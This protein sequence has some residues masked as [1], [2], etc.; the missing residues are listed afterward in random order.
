VIKFIVV[1][2]NGNPLSDV[3]VSF[4]MVGPNGG[5][6]IDPSGDATPGE[7]DVS[8]NDEGIAQ[9][10]LHS[11]YVAGPV[12]ISATIDVLA[13]P[14]TAR[15]SVVS[16]GGGVPS[17]KR[18]SIS[19]ELLNLPGLAYN[20]RTTEITAYLA[21]R[22]GNFNVLK[23]TTVSFASEVGL[24]V[25]TSS[26]TMEEDGM[27]T[28]T[29]RTQKAI[30]PIQSPENVQPEAW[31]I[32]LQDHLRNTY[33][34]DATAHPR[35]GLC[36]ILVYAKGEEH[37]DDSN[38]NGRYDAGEP[39]VDTFDDPF[40]DYNNDDLY[41]DGSADPEELYIDSVPPN[42]VWDGENGVWDENKH[43]FANFPILVTGGPVILCD[44]KTFSIQNGGSQTIKVVVCDQN[45]NQLTPGSRV[46]ISTDVGKVAGRIS[47][48]YINSNAVG[49][50]KPGHLALI[51]YVFTISDSDPGKIDPLEGTITV[52][53][54]WEGITKKYTINGKVD[55]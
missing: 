7:I 15:S 18:F 29:V 27:A 45:L 28:V 6:Y 33:G 17:A 55:Q 10:M 52:S 38:A 12:T 11:G 21:D 8:T 30:A 39:F 23:G 54:N 16:I 26:V 37:F 49:P 42:G 22:F 24:A 41:D 3:S 4:S 51:E 34:Y 48:D 31:E 20:N 14:M 44:T 46:T 53:V 32:E 47:C 5:E 1:N 9:V 13:P 35:D 36:S 50:D 40:C 19:S 25:D 43:I 2:S